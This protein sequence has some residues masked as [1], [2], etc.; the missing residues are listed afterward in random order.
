MAEGDGRHSEGSGK[1]TV[2]DC[3]TAAPTAAAPTNELLPRQFFFIGGSP[4]E[5]S[6]SVF[7]VFL[8]VLVFVFESELLD[9]LGR[10]VACRSR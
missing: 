10:K 2:R 1:L 4:V 9:A 8:F 3:R 5:F 7:V 6:V